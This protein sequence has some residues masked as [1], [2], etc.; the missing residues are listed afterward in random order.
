MTTAAIMQPTYLPWC[1]YFGLMNLVDI[2]VIYDD[3]QFDKRSW[4]QRN[5]IKTPAGSQWLTVPV[6][7]KGQQ[8]Q[9]INDVKISL[10]KD[11]TKNHIKA[12]ETNYSKSR[13]FK[14]YKSLIFE[15]IE[16]NKNSLVDLNYSIITTI[17]KILCIDTKIIRSSELKISGKKEERLVEICKKIK[18]NSYISPQ[19]SKDYLADGS[20]FKTNNINLSYFSFLHPEYTQING[21]FIA[22]MAVIDILFNCGSDRAIELIKQSSLIEKI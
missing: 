13:Y 2:F 9:K 7:S 5:K 18:A 6:A 15:C 16:D 8:F 11:F 20:I 1:G 22:H 10:Q 21:S 12:I 19:G 4:Q 14:E 17:A 3:V